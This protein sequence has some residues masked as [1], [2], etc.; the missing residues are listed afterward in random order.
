M[1]SNEAAYNELCCYTLAHG[2]PSFIHQHVVD[3]FAAQNAD[4]NTKPIKL[5][6]ALIGLYLHVEKHF[7]GREVQRTHQFLAQ[8]K[9]SW[10]SFPLPDDRGS[11]TV[12]EVVA[13]PAGPER[14][15]AIDNW[16]VSIWNAFRD[17]HQAVAELLR[18]LDYD[19]RKSTK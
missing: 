3:S 1:I 2:D 15:K 12:A 4:E 9:R 17:S 16:C 14:D 5:T 6:F 8:R 13:V 18:E 7:S 19:A 11:L 10:P